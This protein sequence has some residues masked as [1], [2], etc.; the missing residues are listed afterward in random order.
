MDHILS[1]VL[2]TPLVGLLVLLFLPSSNA[3]AIKLWANAVAFL[4]GFDRSGGLSRGV[5]VGDGPARG[6]G[7][8]GELALLVHGIDLDDDAIDFVRQIFAF[9]FPGIAESEDLV[10]GLADLAVRLDLEAERAQFLERADRKSRRL[11]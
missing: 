8:K 9:G 1:I 4:N 11:N 3:R 6:F 5:L 2:F 10:D 7:G